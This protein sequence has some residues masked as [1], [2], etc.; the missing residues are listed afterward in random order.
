MSRNLRYKKRLLCG[1]LAGVLVVAAAV[2]LMPLADTVPAFLYISGTL[3]WLGL[4]TTVLW[5]I[6]IHR[7]TPQ[8]FGFLRFFKN[9]PAAVADG[10]LLCLLIVFIIGRA[11]QWHLWVLFSLM[12]LWI[13]SLGLHCLLNGRF[14]TEFKEVRRDAE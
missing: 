3:F 5:A 7:S 6:L 2:L 1:Y 13:L 11:R 12:A 4:I 14:Y 8:A 9:Q 10:A